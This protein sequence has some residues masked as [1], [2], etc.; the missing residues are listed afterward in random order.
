MIT[1][2]PSYSIRYLNGAYSDV[3][4]YAKMIGQQFTETLIA[5]TDCIERRCILEEVKARLEEDQKKDNAT[6]GPRSEFL[7][8]MCCMHDTMRQ[9]II[10]ELSMCGD[11]ASEEKMLANLKNAR[12]DLTLAWRITSDGEWVPN[13]EGRKRAAQDPAPQPEVDAGAPVAKR[14]KQDAPFENP[15][16]AHGPWI[17]QWH[18][19]RC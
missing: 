14:A 8:K 16:H 15:L 17:R 11:L 1:I 18:P 9:T 12:H 2:V 6:Y 13:Y 19:K 4:P 5:H 3:A 10:D 7:S